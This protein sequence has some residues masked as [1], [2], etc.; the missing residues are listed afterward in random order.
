MMTTNQDSLPKCEHSLNHS[1][2]EWESIN[3]L[4]REGE[5]QGTSR[6]VK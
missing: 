4:K 1:D 2:K 6:P 3:F 5:S